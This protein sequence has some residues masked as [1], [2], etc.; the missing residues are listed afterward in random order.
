M[1]N[2]F[3]EKLNKQSL[4]KYIGDISQIAGQRNLNLLAEKQKVLRQLKSKMVMAYFEVY[5]NKWTNFKC[6]IV[7]HCIHLIFLI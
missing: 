2:L 4:R 1:L 6:A 5:P 7:S 3:G